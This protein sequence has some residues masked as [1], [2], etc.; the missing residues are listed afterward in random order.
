MPTD[1]A[2]ADYLRHVINGVSMRKI[3]RENGVHA[4]TV[5]RRIR[6]VEDAREEP[7]FDQWLTDLEQ[8]KRTE[9][10]AQ[11]RRQTCSLAH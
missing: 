1:Q 3:A 6:V 4:S 8:S 9:T 10:P 7:G 2:I 5:L 11:D